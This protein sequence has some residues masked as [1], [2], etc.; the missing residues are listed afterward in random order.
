[1]NNELLARIAHLEAR[2]AGQESRLIKL[3]DTMSRD[4]QP[5]HEKRLLVEQRADSL[6][7]DIEGFIQD[8]KQCR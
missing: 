4:I 1:M 5:D 2:L 3:E 8:R 6:I 7:R